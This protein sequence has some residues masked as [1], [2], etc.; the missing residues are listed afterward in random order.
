M[1]TMRDR[2]RKQSLKGSELT[3]KFRQ[4]P[5]QPDRTHAQ[6]CNNGKFRPT[7]ASLRSA[8]KSQ[9]QVAQA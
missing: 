1:P 9:F 5:Q 8:L 6:Q 2:Q 4:D 7:F 3:R